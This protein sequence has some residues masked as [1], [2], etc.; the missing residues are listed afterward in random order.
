[1]QCLKK[2]LAL[3]KYEIVYIRSGI[4]T[5]AST[6]LCLKTKTALGEIFCYH[7][8]Q[9]KPRT[10]NDCSYKGNKVKDLRPSKRA[11]ENTAWML[12]KLACFNAVTFSRKKELL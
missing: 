12:P 8:N 4:C 10:G 5:A 3:K 7:G 1:M 11:E 6:M 9:T 2:K